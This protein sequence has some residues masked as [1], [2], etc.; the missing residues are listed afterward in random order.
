MGL[1]CVW[2]EKYLSPFYYEYQLIITHMEYTTNNPEKLKALFE[3]LR[4]PKV[5]RPRIQ[6]S[7]K[8][9]INTENLAE[10]LAEE[11]KAA[12]IKYMNE[13]VFVVVTTERAK[14]CSQQQFDFFSDNLP[15]GWN[16][17]AG[18]RYKVFSF[19]KEH[20]GINKVE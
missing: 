6:H 1:D 16:L 19:L 10:R 14:Y 18:E 4:K 13:K 17:I 2:G 3:Y 9:F 7:E 15:V 12:K 5:K 20:F 8:V 11:K